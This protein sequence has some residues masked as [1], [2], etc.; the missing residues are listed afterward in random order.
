[1][2]RF[3]CIGDLHLG[4]G[5]DYG[6]ELG[7]RLRDQEQVWARALELAVEHDVDAILFAGDAFHRRRPN[8]AE[9]RAFQR[10]LERF[11][12]E[13]DIEILAINGN[14]DV[15]AGDLPSALEVFGRDIDLHV[16]PGLWSTLG[17]HDIGVPGGVTVATLPWTPLG[18]LIARR[19]G[20]DR[21]DSHA[22]AAQLLVE[23]ARDLRA[24]VDGTCVLMLHWSVSGAST[25]TGV[26]TDD[27][28]ETVLPLH[29]LEQ[30]GF[31]AIVC[32]H[33]HKAQLLNEEGAN[34]PIFYTGSPAPVDFGEAETAHGCYLLEL[35]GP[36]DEWE[37]TFLP[38]ES[39]PFVTFDVAQVH[40]DEDFLMLT[41][42]YVPSVEQ[43]V[44]A[45]VRVRY[46]A[47]E[48]QARRIDHPAIARALYDAGAHKVYAIQPT[49]EREG[50]ARVDGVDEDIAPLAAVDAW[51][52]ANEISTEH[53]GALVDLTSRYLQEVGS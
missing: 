35:G 44:D 32:G 11:S 43:F 33:I 4:A 29:E 6:R 46:T 40:V 48:E 2:T 15:E 21:D 28:R 31:D 42:G 23:V 53:S 25:P 5:P 3:L 22:I 1:M 16:E 47:T 7:D 26:L 50:R 36:A 10:P 37:L 13:H 27:F 49:I 17:R 18:R 24:Q 45:V 20:G 38:I 41:E 12:A 19:G 34:A 9:L 52:T 51:V 39:R 14:H 30:L 8:P